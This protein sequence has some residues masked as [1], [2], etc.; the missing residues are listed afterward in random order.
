MPFNDLF[1]PCSKKLLEKRS[2]AISALEK[3]LEAQKA[4]HGE[5]VRQL[6]QQLEAQAAAHDE[7]VND[8]FEKLLAE[9]QQVLAY[10]DQGTTY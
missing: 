4:V 8:L 3:L 9:K 7:E 10:C 1:R 6:E 2:L 5:I